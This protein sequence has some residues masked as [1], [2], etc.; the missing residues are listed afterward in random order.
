MFHFRHY[1]VVVSLRPGN[2]LPIRNPQSYTNKEIVDGVDGLYVALRRIGPPKGGELVT[3][4]DGVSNRRKRR[5]L[6]G[7]CPHHS[8]VCNALYHPNLLASFT[9]HIYNLQ[10]YLP[11]DAEQ[12]SC[13]VGYSQDY[14]VGII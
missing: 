1:D 4:G 12:N 8:T 14:V 7:N 11:R 6:A 3:I 2:S 5:A 9:P 13:S 10:H